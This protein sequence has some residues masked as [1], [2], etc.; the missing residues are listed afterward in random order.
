LGIEAFLAHDDIE[1][2]E[3]WRERIVDEL[4]RCDLFVP[5]LSKDFLTSNWAQQEVGFVTAR[6]EVVIMPLSIDRTTPPGFIAK[7]QGKLIPPEGVTLDFLLE[8]LLGLLPRQLVPGQIRKVREAGSFR[9]AEAAMRPL[10][11]HFPNLTPEEAQLLAEASVDNGEV[12]AA[13]LCQ[14]EFLPALINSRGSNI[15]E[16]TLRALQYQ[17]DNQ[18]WYRAEGEAGRT[19]ELVG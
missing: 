4:R 13:Y 5:L 18:S 14:Q 16:G 2:S 7:R 17:L 11:P 9:S 10:V 6:P 12:W 1:V 15:E 19:K 8:L 3:E